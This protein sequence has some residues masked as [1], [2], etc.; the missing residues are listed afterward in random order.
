[1]AGCFFEKCVNPVSSR[2]LLVEHPPARP[3]A[4]AGQAPSL[5]REK[6]AAESNHHLHGVPEFSL[7][8][9]V[10]YGGRSR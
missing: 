9:L 3:L 4:S 8:D 6:K 1:M 10:H 7:V 2:L 5:Q